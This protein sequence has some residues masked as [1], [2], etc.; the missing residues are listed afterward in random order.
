MEALH[1]GGSA[2]RTPGCDSSGGMRV[3][4]VAA[5]LTLAVAA[6]AA[7]APSLGSSGCPLFP[8]DNVWHA[9]VSRL[10]VHPRSGAYLAA[11]GA[12]AGVHADFGS[13]TWEGGPGAAGDR[14]VLVVQAGSC[15]LYEL[16]DAHA[17]GPAARPRARPE[18]APAALLPGVGRR[19]L[20]AEPRVAPVAPGAATTPAPLPDPAAARADPAPGPTGFVPQL[21]TAVLGLIAAALAARGVA[22]RTRQR[23]L[24]DQDR[25][26]NHRSAPGRHVKAEAP[27]DPDPTPTR[28]P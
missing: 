27:P 1:T 15:R 10:P 20:V 28:R 7:G 12:G 5:A 2:P 22:I 23:R 19:S 26:S 21:L 17:A 24:Q 8:A 18:A 16:F 3:L 4:V 9:D 13:G 14:H 6:P 25:P 11:M